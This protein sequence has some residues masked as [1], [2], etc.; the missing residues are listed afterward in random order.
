MRARRVYGQARRV[1]RLVLA[2]A[3][4]LVCLVLA[5]AHRALA[6]GVPEVS[7]RADAEQVE[8]GDL[9]SVTLTVLTDP[10]G[11]AP[12]EPS[13]RASSTIRV[14]P[15][16]ISTRTQVS[17][18]NGRVTQRVGFEARWQVTP[19]KTGQY[20]VGPVTFMWGGKRVSAGNVQLDVKPEGSRPRVRGKPRGLSPFGPGF[21]FNFDDD[22]PSAPEPPA[23][24]PSLS[25]DAPL[26]P[27]AFLRAVVD[28][29]R[30]VVGE[31]VT[32]SV[33]LYVQPRMF[34]PHDPHEPTAPDFFQ[35]PLSG[36][37]SDMRPVVL[38]GA[39]WNAQIIRKVALFPLHAG[40]LEIGP[41]TLTLV[42]LG[43]RGGGI[44]GGLVRSSRPLTVHVEEPNP[45][46][47]PPG[48][49]VGDV[50]S[51]TLVANVEPRAIPQHGS[52]AV[53]LLLRGVGNV[54]S[55]LRLPERKGVT[56]NEA[57]TREAID[58]STGVVSGSRSFTYVVKMSEPGPIDLG[59]VTLPYFD[60][61]AGIYK[62]ASAKLGVVQVLAETAGP[63]PSASA[64]RDP[65]AAVAEAR[66]APGAYTPRGAPISD[67]RWFWL[68]V[69]GAP[70][71]VLLAEGGTRA[72]RRARAARAEAR[73]ST[74]AR[75]KE[76]LA[77]A[78]A[79]NAARD[80][81]TAASEV[82]R[83]LVAAVS[84]A[85]DV[86][87]RGLLQGEVAARL[88]EAGL[89]A[90]L[91]DDVAELLATCDAWRFLP[92]EAAPGGDPIAKARDVTRRLA[93]HRGR[94]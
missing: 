32:L 89:E 5:P 12:G 37:E 74:A 83:A 38:G 87:L 46:G 41:M 58:T 77:R 62:V 48:Y 72:L 7:L 27:Q 69:L 34:Q 75:V 31:Q 63:A 91:A 8:V 42:G 68:A 71:V 76:A 78:E 85:V 67:G 44:R 43:L 56:W 14:S 36:G 66:G 51:Y 94:A 80:G 49:Q 30:A 90:A 86:A 11:G 20:H 28:K 93:K 79:A 23:P 35:R 33:Y 70:A 15:P 21:P 88:R 92:G 61:K 24:D 52:V 57:E 40:D 81:K 50:G 2:S 10:T 53:S 22:P 73:T 6:Q 13:L 45:S 47:R 64:P 16:M 82:E 26:E 55:A 84:G 1:V 4:V 54:P 25:L 29:P 19:T 3:L 9:V 17:I 65:F 60:P 18:V 39:R 59:E